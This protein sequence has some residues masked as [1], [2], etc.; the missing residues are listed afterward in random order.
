[1]THDGKPAFIEFEGLGTLSPQAFQLLT[2]GLLKSL[3]DGLPGLISDE[4]LNEISA[5]TT[6]S[7]IEL[8][9]AGLWERRSDGYYVVEESL[10][11][12]LIDQ[13]EEMHARQQV[14]ADRAFHTPSAD[15]PAQRIC[16]D[17]GKPLN[18]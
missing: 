18:W 12:T 14:C 1:M 16:V 4:Y 10:L 8:D 17:C 5:E 2:F 13:R 9:S 6:I 7:A 11:S 3:E 15:V